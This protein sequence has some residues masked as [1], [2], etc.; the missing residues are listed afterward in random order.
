MS[1]ANMTTRK[2]KNIFIIFEPVDA[3]S[4]NGAPP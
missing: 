1:I 3:G 2:A 4:P